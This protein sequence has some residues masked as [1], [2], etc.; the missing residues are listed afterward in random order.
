MSSLPPSKRVFS[1]NRKFNSINLCLLALGATRSEVYVNHNTVKPNTP[2]GNRR[3]PSIYDFYTKEELF[4]WAKSLHDDAIRKY[5]PDRYRSN[6][7]F[8]DDKSRD[9][10][11][12][13]EKAKK[14]LRYR[15]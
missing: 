14:I 8:Y 12:A 15:G 4:N 1:R 6:K 3:Y 10:N 7:K 11:Q 13:F 2:L 5:H 9:I